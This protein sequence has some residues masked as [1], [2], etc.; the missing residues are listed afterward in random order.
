[1]ALD[2]ARLRQ[3]DGG[4]AEEARILWKQAQVLERASSPEELAEL[5]ET[6]VM[7]DPEHLRQEAEAIRRKLRG[8][9]SSLGSP[10]AGGDQEELLYTHLVNP[11][12]R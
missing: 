3:R 4:Y 11:W 6:A 8:S 7:S 2:V 10:E 5:T 1:M 9:G 12:D